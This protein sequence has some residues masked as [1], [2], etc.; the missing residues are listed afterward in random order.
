MEDTAVNVAAVL[1]LQ[2]FTRGEGERRDAA[3]R[4]GKV[5]FLTVD[6]AANM[7]ALPA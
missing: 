5:N 6:A 4:Y 7:E 3:N 1:D 2:I